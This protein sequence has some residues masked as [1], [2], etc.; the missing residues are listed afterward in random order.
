MSVFG[1]CK[2]MEVVAYGFDNGKIKRATNYNQSE[3]S[4]VQGGCG[5]IHAEIAILDKMVPQV[6]VISHSPCINCARAIVLAGVWAVF[7]KMEYRSREG[8]EYLHE[9]KVTCKQLEKG[10]EVNHLTLLKVSEQ[11]KRVYDMV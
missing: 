10:E 2:R 8:I 6:M 9:K 11:S 7:Y 1:K 4:G 5:C 3:C